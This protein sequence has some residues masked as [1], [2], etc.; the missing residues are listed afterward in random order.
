MSMTDSAAAQMHQKEFSLDVVFKA[1][2]DHQSRNSVENKHRRKVNLPERETKEENKK[3]AGRNVFVLFLFCSSF[4]VFLRRL[5]FGPIRRLFSRQFNQSACLSGWYY[6][7]VITII[8]RVAQLFQWWYKVKQHQQ[9]SFTW[10]VANFEADLLA[11]SLLL[12]FRVWQTT[13]RCNSGS[14]LVNLSN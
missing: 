12:A 5:T 9:Q 1:G 11:P 4:F 10:F 6:L 8:R 3:T 7:A 2:D 14:N 13:S